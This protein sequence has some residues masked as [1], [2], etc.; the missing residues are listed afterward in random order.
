MATTIRELLTRLGVDADTVSVKRF[1]TAIEQAKVGMERAARIATVLT[2][3]VAAVTTGIIAQTV[4]TASLSEEIIRQSE[5]LGVTIEGYQELTG[6]FEDFG[7]EA[8]DVADVFAT[9][10]DRAEDAA[11]AGS[12][13]ADDFALVGLKINKEFLDKS[14]EERFLAFADAVS[15]TESDSKRLAATARILGD[16]IGRKLGPLL[17]QGADGIARLRKEVR[18]AGGVID[19]DGVRAAAEAARSFRLFGLAVQGVR[20]EVGVAFAPVVRRVTDRITNWV[21]ANR[22]LIRQRLQDAVKQIENAVEALDKQFQRVD[23]RVREDVGG[24]EVVFRQVGKASAFAGLL[25]VLRALIPVIIGVGTAISGVTLASAP[26]LLLIGLIAVGLL[27]LVLAGEDFIVFLRGGKSVIGDFLTEFD[28]AE[29]VLDKFDQLLKAAKNAGEALE[30]VLRSLARVLGSELLPA[31]EQI[32]EALEGLDTFI[33]ANIL[34]IEAR[35]ATLT[36]ILNAFADALDL[37]E[38]VR[39]GVSLATTGAIGAEP[40]EALRGGVGRAAQAVAGFAPDVQ[41]RVEQVVSGVVGRVQE[42]LGLTGERAGQAAAAAGTTTII[43]EGDTINTTVL[44]SAEEFS[45]MLDA[46]EARNNRLAM[47][48]ARGGER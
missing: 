31:T 25:A 3:A 42:R 16:G 15:K 44:T 19:E 6:V 9:I 36:D 30:P 20:N 7:A 5:N 8:A 14:P 39:A 10:S 11:V 21:R 27:A 12:S 40:R 41:S 34:N 24:W 46:R 23:K 47:A 38:E 13:M 32:N 1:D 2:G 4:A 29:P 17:L 18:L 22:L 28:R 35:I 45:A 33:L 48:D 43:R 26:W 37:F